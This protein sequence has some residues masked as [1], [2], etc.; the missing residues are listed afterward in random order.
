[1]SLMFKMHAWQFVAATYSSLMYMALMAYVFLGVGWLVKPQLRRS[2]IAS[3]ILTTP[4]AIVILVEFFSRL[5]R[6]GLYS[7]LRASCTTITFYPSLGVLFAIFCLSALVVASADSPSIRN[8][9]SATLWSVT[10][11]VAVGVLYWRV[12]SE[13]TK[14]VDSD[15]GCPATY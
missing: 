14:V 11:A 7:A 5:A 3:L 12:T 1:M 6:A 4:V 10:L 8:T 13:F 9:S 15:P 2:P